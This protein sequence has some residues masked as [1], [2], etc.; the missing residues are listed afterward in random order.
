MKRYLILYHFVLLCITQTAK[1]QTVFN[2][3]FA[4]YSS[5]NTAPPLM[6]T[7]GNAT[8]IQHGLSIFYSNNCTG[9]GFASNGWDTSDY[10]QINTSTMGFLGPFKLGFDYRFSDK[11]IGNFE[12]QISTNGTTFTKIGDLIGVVPAVGCSTYVPIDLNATYSNLPNLSIRIYKTNDAVSG[13]NRLRLD[14]IFLQATALPVTVSYFNVSALQA[15]KKVIIDWE[16]ISETNSD[17]FEIQ[18]SRDAQ[19][20][21]VI[22]RVDAFGD[23][24]GKHAYQFTDNIPAFGVNYY[25]LRQVDKDGIAEIFRVQSAIIDDSEVVKGVFPNPVIT[26]NFMVKIENTDTYTLSLMDIWGNEVATKN[27]KITDTILSIT[28]LE[29]LKVGTYSLRILNENGLNIYKFQVIK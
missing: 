9:F 2:F 4:T 18:Q 22:G 29:S 24:D 26:S 11:D 20:Y 10:V 15:N 28:P 25:R 16:T 19:I 1:A 7:I 5:D 23:S 13:L 3:D 14:N 21:T 6:A 17:Y 8:L 27:E 12:V